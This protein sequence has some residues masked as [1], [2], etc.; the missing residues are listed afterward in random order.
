[1]KTIIIATFLLASLP[2]VTSA[3]PTWVTAPIT[4]DD[5]VKISNLDVMKHEIDFGA[6]RYA[7]LRFEAYGETNDTPFD[8]KVSKVTLLTYIPSEGGDF[9]IIS[10]W[11]D[12]NRE[13]VEYKCAVDT[14]KN[15]YTKF[16]IEDGNFTII[17]AET[18]DSKKPTYKIKIITSETKP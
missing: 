1:M 14:T 9:R 11:M 8:T 17:A 6:E 16:T 7:T 2:I 5:I 10:I 3:E 4:G 12:G 18:K 15:R 13:T